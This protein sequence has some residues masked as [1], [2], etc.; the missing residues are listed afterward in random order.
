MLLLS[1]MVSEHAYLGLRSLVALVLDSIPMDAELDVR[2]KEFG[3]KSS[4]LSRLGNAVEGGVTSLSGFAVHGLTTTRTVEA[5]TIVVTTTVTEGPSSGS[6]EN[7]IGVQL[8]RSSLKT[9]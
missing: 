9:N 1:L 5:D 7:D 2:K 6:L 4:W 3:V 8:I